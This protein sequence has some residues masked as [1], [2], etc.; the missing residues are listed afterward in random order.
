MSSGRF[1]LLVSRIDSGDAPSIWNLLKEFGSRGLTLE[2]ISALLKHLDINLVP[3]IVTGEH[4]REP[5]KTYADRALPCV[6]SLTDIALACR[7]HPSFKDAVVPQI[8]EKIDG[9]CLWTNYCLHFGL[10]FPERP[11]PGED[12]RKAYFA[13]SLML[14]TLVELYPEI[15]QAMFSSNAFAGLMIR[16]WMTQGK[17]RQEFMRLNDAKA[18]P[19]LS[20]MLSALRNET[21]SQL[22]AQRI[23]SRGSHL[24]DDFARSV[25]AR[26]R[27]LFQ[28][29]SQVSLS[30]H[31]GSLGRLVHIAWMARL[32]APELER[33]FIKVK[34]MLEF[35]KALHLVLARVQT[36]SVS[37]E[38]MLS[39]RNTTMRLVEPGI[40]GRLYGPLIWREL[41]EGDVYG[42][43]LY[44]L[45]QGGSPG[46][47]EFLKNACG[48]MATY[49]VYPCVLKRLD[50]A[51]IPDGVREK[52]G[53][54]RRLK[55]FWLDFDGTLQT[56]GEI[57][58][59]MPEGLS[60]C[61]N[62]RCPGDRLA[63][64]AL[65]KQCSHCHTVTYCSKQCQ[66]EDWVR[67]HRAECREASLYHT[68]GISYTH[69]MRR[70]H[71]Y[72]IQWVYNAEWQ[73]V[74]NTFASSWPT[75]GLN[76]WFV[77]IQTNH[78]QIKIHPMHLSLL[79][80]DSPDYRPEHGRE[81]VWWERDFVDPFKQQYLKPRVK[82]IVWGL[83]CR[84]LRETLLARE[85]YEEGEIAVAEGVFHMGPDVHVFLTVPLTRASAGAKWEARHGV[86]RHSFS[87]DLAE[88][89]RRAGQ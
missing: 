28:S 42:V 80:E 60:I 79:P 16:L 43:L 15:S 69:A 84:T 50:K 32:A 10:S 58:Q 5:H 27:Q 70:F 9:I 61:D 86:A 47:V 73:D 78:I 25:V 77:L 57:L 45:A 18:C 62:L 37:T 89:N 44:L 8:V 35:G 38:V 56:R 81:E 67:Y 51:R 19:I 54:N 21:F 39:L 14:L 23:A 68:H 85:G 6:T 26:T 88:A 22:F 40:N 48:A 11:G 30:K 52:L 13:H 1:R 2:A 12:F 87:E 29:L 17:R 59:E 75:L 64:E 74:R 31:V 82:E 55:D 49:T 46:E 7:L 72:F 71:V 33:S 24:P 66:K 3:N 20:L 34:Y 65:V 41:V 83:K 63:E 4:T 76:E 36:E 53:E